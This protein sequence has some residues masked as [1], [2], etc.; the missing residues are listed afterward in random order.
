MA[1]RL[2]EDALRALV[3]DP[4]L[5]LFSIEPHPGDDVPPTAATFRDRIVLGQVTVATLEQR[6]MIAEI[7]QEGLDRWTGS[8]VISCFN[9]RHAIQVSDGELKHDFLICF[10]CGRLNYYPPGSGIRHL[11]IR[12]EAGLFNAILTAARVPLSTEP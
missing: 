3:S 6:Q 7:L 12:S 4:E 9:P 8:H 1:N 11:N 10:E 2:P 5:V